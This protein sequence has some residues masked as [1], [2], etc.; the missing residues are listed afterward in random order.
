MK[1]VDVIVP[2]RGGVADDVVEGLEL[3]RVEAVQAVGSTA[4]DVALGVLDH[5]KNVVV[6]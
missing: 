3:T 5:A 4:P 6:R 1:G 2:Q